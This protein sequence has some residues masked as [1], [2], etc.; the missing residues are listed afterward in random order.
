VRTNDN[1]DQ[2]IYRPIRL[3]RRLKSRACRLAEWPSRND[4]R[5]VHAVL[6]VLAAYSLTFFPNSFAN[7][8]LNIVL[9]SPEV[10]RLL[11]EQGTLDKAGDALWENKERPVIDMWEHPEKYAT[12]RS[13]FLQKM[14]N[15]RRLALPNGSY[16]W[17][18]E[19]SSAKCFL[20]GVSTA[21]FQKVRITGWR[22]HGAEGWTCGPVAPF[23]DVP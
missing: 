14:A 9:D 15:Q 23:V 3:Q 16:L 7:A 18:S 17:A 20:D 19:K 21:V 2:N 10:R 11:L 1:T 5:G 8:K 22:H 6:A 4:P 12:G 13:K